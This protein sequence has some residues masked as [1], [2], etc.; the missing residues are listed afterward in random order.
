MRKANWNIWRIRM[1]RTVGFPN[2]ADE[3]SG[4]MME[5][6]MHACSLIAERRDMNGHVFDIDS[7]FL[8]IR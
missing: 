3:P 8:V 2:S 7:V 6:A 1:G 4:D 5:G